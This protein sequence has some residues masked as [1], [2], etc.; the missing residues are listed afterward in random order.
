MKIDTQL[1][2][3][4]R[5]QTVLKSLNQSYYCNNCC[6]KQFILSR[7]AIYIFYYNVTT[8]SY[9][10]VDTVIWKKCSYVPPHNKVLIVWSIHMIVVQ[11]LP[12]FIIYP[13]CIMQSMYSI[14][15]HYNHN[16]FLHKT[17]G[18]VLCL[19]GSHYKRFS[20]FACWFL[21]KGSLFQFLSFLSIIFIK[22]F[23]VFF[24][25]FFY[26]IL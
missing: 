1:P 8:N 6:I 2:N 5:R 22:I 24:F 7:T 21:A 12:L 14:L 3:V 25:P 19:V 15:L 11:Y 20:I 13:N 9:K 10:K 18:D 23:I 16:H 4:L 26:L 17:N